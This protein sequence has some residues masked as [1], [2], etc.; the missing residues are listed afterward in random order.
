[1][2]IEDRAGELGELQKALEEECVAAG[3]AREARPF[4]PHL[5]VARLRQPHGSRELAA[6]HEEMGFE[7]EAVKASALA[8]VRSEL[9]SEGSRHTVISRHDFQR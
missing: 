7:A 2:G 1:M 5:T 9:R 4:R 8:V 3:F 6:L